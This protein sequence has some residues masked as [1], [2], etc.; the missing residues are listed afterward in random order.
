MVLPQVC[1]N[2]LAML[3]VLQCDN[4]AFRALTEEVQH[5]T[6]PFGMGNLTMTEATSLSRVK[7][8][9]VI[10]ISVCT[11]MFLLGIPLESAEEAA[12]NIFSIGA[13]KTDSLFRVLFIAVIVETWS[14][15]RAD[16]PRKKAI[17]GLIAAVKYTLG[18]ILYDVFF[19]GTFIANHHLLRKQSSVSPWAR[20]SH[21]FHSRS[22]SNMLIHP[23]RCRST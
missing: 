22:N 5:M 21:C 15:S 11:P 12:A 2:A 9:Y 13:A 17:A 18:A 10:I 1:L 4:Y 14:E 16:L 8:L 23:A 3:F 7:A 6:E 19:F 20:W